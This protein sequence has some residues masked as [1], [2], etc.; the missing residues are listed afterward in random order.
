MTDKV[1][2]RIVSKLNAATQDNSHISLVMGRV[3]VQKAAIMDFQ[4]VLAD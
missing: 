3:P 1:M 2:W 4:M